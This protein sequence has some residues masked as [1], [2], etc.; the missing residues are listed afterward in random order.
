MKLRLL[1]LAGVIIALIAPAQHASANDGYLQYTAYTWEGEPG[2]GEQCAAGIFQDLDLSFDANP[3]PGCPADGFYLEITGSIYSPGPATTYT[4]LSDDGIRVTID[5]LVVVNEW[6]DRGCSGFTHALQLAEGWH[7][8]SV[9]FYENGGGTCLQV[10]QDQGNGPQP[11]PATYLAGKLPEPSTTTTTTATT[12]TTDPP[13]VT[14]APAT[15]LPEPVR[16][17]PVTT[18]PEPPILATTSTTYQPTESTTAQTTTSTMDTI[19]QTSP[20]TS[21]TIPEIPAIVAS[22]SEPI[23]APETTSTTTTS[24]M[25]ATI[26]ERM[27]NAE[28]VAVITNAAAVAELTPEQAG[29]LFAA[30]DESAVTPELAAAIIEAV[31]DAPPSIRE[32]FEQEIN[33]FGGL[34]DGYVPLGS[35]VPVGTRRIIIITSGLLVAMPSTRRK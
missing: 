25:A 21:S 7:Q 13:V 19:S 16:P 26:T 32:E 17:P 12:T 22:T 1:P 5:G 34:Y 30:I 3:V 23:R 29:D 11:I 24:S 33:I 31:Q 2:R 18:V 15:T 14:L 35:L 27:T 28:A 4:I 8:L 10:F 6:W 9:E 20:T